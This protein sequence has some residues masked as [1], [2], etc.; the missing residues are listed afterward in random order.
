MKLFT[1]NKVFKEFKFEK[2]IDFEKE[3]VVNS[4]LFFGSKTIYIDAKK[5]I[6]AKSI[7]KTIPD[8]FLFD[9]SDKNNPEFYLVEVELQN[10]DFYSHI[11]QQITKFFGFYKNPKS[12][13]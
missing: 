1:Y 2:E 4:K 13:K 10:H 5:K 8:G 12:L 11:F 9:L 7:G 6:E 3:V